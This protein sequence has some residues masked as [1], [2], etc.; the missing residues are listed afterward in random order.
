MK[1][2]NLQ[3]HRAKLLLDDFSKKYPGI[4]QSVDAFRAQ[5]GLNNFEWPDWCFMP[6]STCVHIIKGY[7]FNLTAIQ[8]I[9]NA[10]MLSALSKW[11]IGQGIYRFDSILYDCLIKTEL[12]GD[13]PSELLLKIPQWC[14]YIETPGHKIDAHAIKGCFVH[15]EYNVHSK[16]PEVHFVF[17]SDDLKQG[18]FSFI[19]LGQWSLQESISKAIDY[20][21]HG[22]PELLT[23]QLKE[24]RKNR[25]F[26]LKSQSD[27]LRPIISLL[28]YICSIN[29]EYTNKE[30]PSNAPITKTKKG[31]RTFPSNQVKTWEIGTRIGAAIRRALEKSENTAGDSSKDGVHSSLQPHVRRAHWHGFWS[32]P[33]D[34]DRHLKIKWLPPIPVNIEEFEKLPSVIH[35]VQ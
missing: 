13:I 16:T 12:N 21:S 31:F 27:V 10:L 7:D 33:K 4:W 17:D 30:S 14:L 29:A 3:T 23:N 28:L 2:N 34:G 1:N 8:E 11:R 22:T 6:N 15:L 35:P 18:Q 9:Q 26:I 19:K 25:E 32:G 20:E 5:K 24:V